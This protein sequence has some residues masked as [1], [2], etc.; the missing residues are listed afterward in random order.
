VNDKREFQAKAERGV[1]QRKLAPK[2]SVHSRRRIAVKKNNQERNREE[3]ELQKLELEVA[4]E[5]S[6]HSALPEKENQERSREKLELEKI[7]LEIADA[8][9][10]HS[11]L[12]EKENQERNREKLELEKLQGEIQH[13]KRMDRLE[14]H[15]A[16]LEIEEKRLATR[17]A[18]R[19]A[20]W[21]IAKYFVAV[22]PVL[23]TLIGLYVTYRKD[24]ESLRHQIELEQKFK[25][26]TAA[27]MLLKTLVDS[28]NP[29]EII[30]TAV[31]LQA[32]GRWGIRLLLRHLSIDHDDELYP[33]FVDSIADILA[34]ESDESKQKDGANEVVRRIIDQADASIDA[35]FIERTDPDDPRETIVKAHLNAL[36]QL[37]SR[38]ANVCKVLQPTLKAQSTRITQ[39]VGKL[40]AKP[41]L[42][43][44]H[45]KLRLSIKAVKEVINSPTKSMPRGN[46]R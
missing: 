6:R 13:K 18:V 46:Q 33:L 16:I 12:P 38:C 24:T 27:F 40:E 37:A 28:N 31:A 8:K 1:E 19:A 21:D 34:A 15:K 4:G 36:V 23:A 26:D 10:R 5:K 35:F 41:T 39:L 43:E 29:V 2:A 20:A 45:P 25:V 44:P 9:S 30:Q 32:Y 14:R 17:F 7:E 22:L 42:L 11:A 3:L